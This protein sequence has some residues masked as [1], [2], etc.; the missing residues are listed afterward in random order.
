LKLRFHP[1]AA[2][3]AREARRWY[4]ARNEQAST[5]FV[6]AYRRTLDSIREAP[7]RWPAH[8]HGTRRVVLRGFPYSVV[9]RASDGAVVVVAV[10]H[11]KRRPGYWRE[12]TP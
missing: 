7:E 6:V 3:E 11:D 8:R 4:R 10:A 1:E 2:V 9:Y 12:R 5:A